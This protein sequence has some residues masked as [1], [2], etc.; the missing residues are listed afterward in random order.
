MAE[1]ESLTLEEYFA[2]ASDEDIIDYI[3]SLDDVESV[4]P[5]LVASNRHSLILRIYNMPEYNNSRSHWTN[6]AIEAHNYNLFAELMKTPIRESYKVYRKYFRSIFGSPSSVVYI[7]TLKMMRPEVL[8]SPYFF[9]LVTRRANKI[10]YNYI[11]EKVPSV[12]HYIG[13]VLHLVNDRG[14]A[15][16][17]DFVEAYDNNRRL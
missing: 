17:Y 12:K 3:A 1:E 15:K 14:D 4:L 5:Y 6:L 9:Y 10:E 11:V 7:A 16:T 8:E 2:D 13:Q